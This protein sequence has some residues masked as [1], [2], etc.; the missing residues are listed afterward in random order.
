MQNELAVLRDER[1]Q[2]E[3]AEE[4]EVV[5]QAFVTV[6]DIGLDAALIEAAAF[7]RAH[8]PA[9]Y[10]ALFPKAASDMADEAYAKEIKEART[11]VAKL[12]QLDP[13]DPVR[14]EFSPRVSAL[15][16]ALE[17]SI[18]EKDDVERGARLVRLQLEKRRAAV[19]LLRTQVFGELLT[20]LG[21]KGIANRFF[22]SASGWKKDTEGDA[23]APSPSGGAPSDPTINP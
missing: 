3:R 12:D 7:V 6:K 1:D 20:L 5:A 21:N 18:Q 17:T 9:D 16:A 2:L 10:E 19:N 11:V 4:L 8:H 13:D 23:P 14:M 15:A 22:R